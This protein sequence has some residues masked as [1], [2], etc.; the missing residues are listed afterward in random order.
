[1]LP[2]WEEDFSIHNDDIDSQHKVLFNLAHKA[3][4]MA[5]NHIN[6]K[7]LK[8][9]LG[10]FFEYMKVHFNDEEQYMRQIGYPKLDEHIE[11]HKYIVQELKT[12]I[13]TIHS[14]NDLKEKLKVVSQEWLLQHILQEDMQIEKYRLS[15][16]L[17]DIESKEKKNKKEEFY[18]EEDDKPS[19]FGYTCSCPKKVHI[20]SEKYHNLIQ[21]EKKILKCKNC[22]SPIT[23][24]QKR[25]K[26]CKES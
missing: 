16:A 7:E 21:K 5:N 14:A 2:V 17:K 26:G 13:K 1:M 19:Q 25:Y 9:V 23:Y 15:Q 6:P 24:Q 10:E 12:T 22:K 8:Q 20:L 18:I 4:N 3:Y 11:L